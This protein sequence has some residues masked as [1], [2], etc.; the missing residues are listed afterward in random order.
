M[1]EE[2]G[3]G[4]EGLKGMAKKEGLGEGKERKGSRGRGLCPLPPSAGYVTVN[5]N[6]TYTQRDC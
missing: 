4:G 1:N 5:A 2:K 6:V 3:K